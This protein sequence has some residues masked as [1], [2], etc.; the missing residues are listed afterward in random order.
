MI[1]AEKSNAVRR[2]EFPPV[3]QTLVLK[4]LNSNLFDV[5]CII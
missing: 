2:N 1:I 5:F 3:K 4:Y